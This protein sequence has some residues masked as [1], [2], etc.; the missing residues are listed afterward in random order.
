MIKRTSWL[1]VCSLALLLAF[2]HQGTAEAQYYPRPYFSPHGGGADAAAERINKAK[3]TIDIAMYSIS[4][5]GPIW[6]ALKK[7]TQRG[8]RVRIILN[9]GSSKKSFTAKATALENIG[10]HVFKVTR[11]MHEKFA[12]FDSGTWYRRKLLNGS[13]N[14][15]TGAETRY[16]ENTVLYGRHYH[17]F[18]A[19]QQEFNLLLSKASPISDGAED[20]MQ[21]VKLNK[22]S[23]Y[24][25]RYERAVFSSANH[26][27]GST[28]ISDEI[29]ALMQKAKKSIIIDVAHFNSK[30]IANALIAIR[31][32]KPNLKIEVLL[33]MGE[34]GDKKSRCK[35]LERAKIDVRYKM[36]SLA[37]H[38]PRS[39]LQ[40]HKTM[41]VDD[42]D[43]ITGSYN[44]S[45]TAEDSNY[46][47]I[48]VVQGHV[49]RNKKMV[50]A[51]L[52]EHDK[53]W[54]LGNDVYARFL[55]AMKAEPG[56]ANYKPVVPIHFDTDYFR[57]VMTLTRKQMA[58][59]R[60]AASKS[61]VWADRKNKESSYVNRETA[62]VLTKSEAKNL[63]GTF[64]DTT[65]NGDS[66]G[67]VGGLPD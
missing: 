9:K 42:R 3:E 56:D 41:I 46:E 62:K 55:S 27:T 48:I 61:G 15:S 6:E 22:P 14:W 26:D 11:T 63:T 25:R 47:N 60:S 2:G 45:D 50:K 49:R 28:V 16:S 52:D 54:N 58:P 10:V 17:L 38:H 43:M 23:K 1:S 39:Q 12:L 4:T 13:A 67:L 30:R 18:Y 8:V 34:Y 29:V 44:W 66:T 51:F 64:L 32:S 20:H 31:N 65:P 36:Y 53:L 35:E 7:A 40:H 59:L 57:A 33:D 37:F 21:P 19:F 24:T 5:S